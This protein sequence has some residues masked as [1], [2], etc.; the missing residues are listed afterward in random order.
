M[1]E[2]AGNH[3]AKAL[4]AAGGCFCS[5]KTMLCPKDRADKH[6]RLIVRRYWNE[7]F[8]LFTRMYKYN[9]IKNQ[10][11]DYLSVEQPHCI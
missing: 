3:P 4:V 5:K 2:T 8:A 1:T 7:G 11:I 6:Q 9:L 10:R